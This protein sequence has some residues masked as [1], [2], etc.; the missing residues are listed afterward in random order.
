MTSRIYTAG[1]AESVDLNAYVSGVTVDGEFTIDFE[2][3]LTFRD[4][5]FVLA[6]GW[7]TLKNHTLTGK[8]IFTFNYSNSGSSKDEASATPE[9]APQTPKRPRLAEDSTATPSSELEDGELPTE[10]DDSKKRTA[11][12]TPSQAK[13]VQGTFSADT[14]TLQRL[15]HLNDVLNKQ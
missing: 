6:K 11:R 7:V 12:T 5:A 15:V 14:S 8:E 3:P 2:R 1:L 9:E 4:A 13:G 10:S